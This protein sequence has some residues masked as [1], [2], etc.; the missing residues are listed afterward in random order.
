MNYSWGYVNW[1]G[2]YGIPR[3]TVYRQEC[4]SIVSIKTRFAGTLKKLC[5]YID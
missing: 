5:W 2:K 4:Y 1:C 3:R